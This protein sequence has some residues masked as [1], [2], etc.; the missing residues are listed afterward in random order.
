MLT[1]S[2]FCLNPMV[3]N[4]PVWGMMLTENRPASSRLMVRLIPSTATEPLT[5][6]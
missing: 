1:G 3:V 5:I 6:M 4:L 2:P